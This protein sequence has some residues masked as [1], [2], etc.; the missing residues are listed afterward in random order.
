MPSQK[1]SRC[2]ASCADQL[3][4]RKLGEKRVMSDRHFATVLAGIR[5]CDGGLP[6]WK[7]DLLRRTSHHAGDA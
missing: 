2:N 5:R 1:T 4:S 7:G 6:V 3:T